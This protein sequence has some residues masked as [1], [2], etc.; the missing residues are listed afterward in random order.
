MVWQGKKDIVAG[1]KAR[2]GRQKDEWRATE[3]NMK[4]DGG[5]GKW[6]K[7]KSL[8]FRRNTETNTPRGR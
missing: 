1:R 8:H 6:A 4:G 2:E 7:K 5:D 3:R